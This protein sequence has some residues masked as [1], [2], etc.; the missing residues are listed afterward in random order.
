[1]QNS[2]IKFQVVVSQI[3]VAGFL[4]ACK[5]DPLQEQAKEI[6]TQQALVKK[7]QA[8][9]EERVKKYNEIAD[10]QRNKELNEWRSV[11]PDKGVDMS[12]KSRKMLARFSSE[13]IE[14]GSSWPTWVTLKNGWR[15]SERDL[16]K[17]SLG[18]PVEPYKPVQ[19]E[20][21]ITNNSLMNGYAKPGGLLW[22]N[23][24]LLLAGYDTVTKL[25]L[26]TNDKAQAYSAHFDVTTG[27]V[28]YSP[29][30]IADVLRNSE[31]E[32]VWQSVR[33]IARSPANDFTVVLKENGRVYTVGQEKVINLGQ[34]GPQLTDEAG[35]KNYVLDNVI[36]IAAG[37][38]H[39]LAL[40]KDGTVWMWGQDDVPAI[41]WRSYPEGARQPIPRKIDL[42]E[43]V[44]KIATGQNTSF[45][46]TKSGKIWGWGRPTCGALGILRAEILGYWN[47]A[48]PQSSLLIGPGFVYNKDAPQF[49]QP[50][51]KP[52]LIFE[53]SNFTDIAASGI[54]AVALSKDGQVWGW[55]QNEFNQLG[56][57]EANVSEFDVGSKN[58]DARPGLG[59]GIPYPMALP[60]PMRDVKNI[61]KIVTSQ[62]GELWEIGD[63]CRLCMELRSQQIEYLRQRWAE[64]LAKAMWCDDK[65]LAKQLH[66][67]VKNFFEELM[68]SPERNTGRMDLKKHSDDLMSGFMQRDL[69]LFY[70][71]GWDNESQKV[72]V[73][74]GDM[75]LN[76]NGRA[77]E[78]FK[79][80]SS[81]ASL[82]W[83]ELFGQPAQHGRIGDGNLYDLR[84][85]R[86]TVNK[87]SKELAA[88]AT[89]HCPAFKAQI[90]E[91]FKLIPMFM[92]NMTP[93]RNHISQY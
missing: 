56:A 90:N 21:Y 14:Y 10:K 91:E 26:P 48:L 86:W 64:L 33:A 52:R 84:S 47:R 51:I 41:E 71:Q 12:W 89:Q 15:Y 85:T 24:V 55:G 8:E 43:P 22:S 93:K 11:N 76:E 59:I 44:V 58:C 27:A 63:G 62:T 2:N 69:S 16:I 46:L 49:S 4:L 78:P 18:L 23:G 73:A 61:Q 34:L 37:Q 66:T 29:E 77:A 28:F 1:M 75:V 42:P 5:P 60:R 53:T 9:D 67:S 7:L 6:A 25:K 79:T 82:A 54:H 3:L 65:D 35:I 20:P 32:K 13:V 50:V 31:H 19:T 70:I 36:A 45:A 40:R 57:N 68:T 38:R 87:D 30:L 80:K 39:A 92:E 88:F 72:R 81:Q 17:M 74:A 83:S